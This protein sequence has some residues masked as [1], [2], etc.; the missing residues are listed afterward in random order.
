MDGLIKSGCNPHHKNK[1]GISA[2]DIRR[3]MHSY[4][5]MRQDWEGDGCKLVCDTRHILKDART[6]SAK[7]DFCSQRSFEMG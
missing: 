2:L 1:Y 3:Q 7:K 6:R 5:A 4:G